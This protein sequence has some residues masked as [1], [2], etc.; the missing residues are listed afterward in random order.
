MKNRAGMFERYSFLRGLKLGFAAFGA[1]IS[2][3]VNAVLLS[4]AYI[5]GIG[6]TALVARLSRKKFLDVAKRKTTYWKP[7]SQRMHKMEES[8]RQF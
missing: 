7:V 8:Y 1:N 2:A 4:V 5:V 3:I 6:L